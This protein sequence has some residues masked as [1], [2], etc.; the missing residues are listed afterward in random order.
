MASLTKQMSAWMRRV[1]DVLSKRETVSVELRENG[2]VREVRDWQTIEVFG[3]NRAL[4]AEAINLSALD[5]LSRQPGERGPADPAKRLAALKEQ[6]EML[7]QSAKHL[8]GTALELSIMINLLQKDLPPRPSKK[9]AKVRR[10]R[11]AKRVAELEALC[12]RPRPGM[13]IDGGVIGNA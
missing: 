5:R 3:S 9:L 10:K 13:L 11:I 7:L 4:E 8:V 12:R 2:V 1:E 6:R